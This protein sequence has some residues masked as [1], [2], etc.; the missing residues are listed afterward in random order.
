MS[1]PDEDPRRE[2]PD[3]VAD[4]VVDEVVDARG[5][6]CPLPVIRLARQAREAAPGSVLEVWATDPAAAADVP[7]WCRLRGHDYLGAHADRGADGGG[8][9]AYRV[10][11]SPADADVRP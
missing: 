3:E 5:L 8:W 10:R 1:A 6:A 9:T 4:E 11:L 7:A 2:G